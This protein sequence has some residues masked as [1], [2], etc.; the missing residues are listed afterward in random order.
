MM[1]SGRE[2]GAEEHAVG[3]LLMD[4]AMCYIDV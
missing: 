2:V 4:L 3:L 1:M